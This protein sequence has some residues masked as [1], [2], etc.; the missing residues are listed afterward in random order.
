MSVDDRRDNEKIVSFIVPVL[1]ALLGAAPSTYIS[2]DMANKLL[3]STTINKTELLA[4]SKWMARAELKHDELARDI[5]SLE[6]RMASNQL[7]FYE[8]SP[9]EP[10][11]NVVHF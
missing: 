2:I 5:R 7:T 6:I 3:E 1:A 9:P 10:H 11:L 4:R 8:Y